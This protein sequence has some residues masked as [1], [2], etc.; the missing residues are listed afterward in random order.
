MREVES[1]GPGWTILGYGRRRYLDLPLL[2]FT[3]KEPVDALRDTWMLPELRVIALPTACA[4]AD[5]V[6]FFDDV[7]MILRKTLV[8]WEATE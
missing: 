5:F 3:V 8:V 1:P 7:A 2:R 4:E 6:T